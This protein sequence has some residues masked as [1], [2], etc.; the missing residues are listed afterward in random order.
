MQTRNLDS[1]PE[2]L[3]PAGNWDCARAAAGAIYFGL[4]LFNARPRADISSTRISVDRVSNIISK[5][6]VF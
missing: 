2:L 1:T 3:A 4:P 6:G 5:Q